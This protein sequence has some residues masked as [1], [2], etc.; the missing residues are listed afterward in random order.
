MHLTTRI[1]N[2]IIS[3]DR[4]PATPELTYQR[5]SSKQNLMGGICGIIFVIFGIFLFVTKAVTLF[6]KS[7]MTLKTYI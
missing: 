3:C 7:E 2:K 6:K 1:K 4:D 5:V